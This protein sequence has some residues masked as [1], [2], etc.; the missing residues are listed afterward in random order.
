[1]KLP[2]AYLSYDDSDSKLLHRSNEILTK[3]FGT[4]KYTYDSTQG[5]VLFIASGGSERHSIELTKNEKNVILLCHRE[6]N[7][8]AAAIEIAAYLRSENKR[9]ELID[10]MSGNA[11]EDFLNSQKIFGALDSLSRQKAA[12]IGEVSDW[13]IISDVE[14][15]VI[16][17]KLGVELIR[18]P[19]EKFESYKEMEPSKEFLNYFQDFKTDNLHETARVYSLLDKIVADY[20]LSAISVE[21]FSMVMRDKVTAC[22]PL[23]VL[24]TRN[25][26]AACEGDVC[27]MIGKILV[28]TI[29]DSIPWQANIAELKNG[30]VLLAH[31]TAPLH[32]LSSFDITTHFE[33]NCGTAIQGKV[34]YK[35][36]GVFRVD[37]KLEKYMLL[38]GQISDTPNLEYAC[39]TQVVFETTE[40]ETELLKN[41][42]LGNHHLVFPAEYIPLLEKLMNVLGLSKV[43]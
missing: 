27:S 41:K 39:R 37:S 15:D 8:Y 11:K 19:W 7:S 36:I 17:N 12:V 20:D 14:N 25:I 23:S 29:T 40:K 33:T 13:L 6:S 32:L 16:S 30:T 5:K 4:E 43:S 42:S 38:E 35:N 10:V 3:F 34:D 26:V 18:L 28:R 2:L 21:C 22:L 1:M 9:V 24:N 31:C